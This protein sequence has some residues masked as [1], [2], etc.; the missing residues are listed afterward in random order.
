MLNAISGVEINRALHILQSIKFRSSMV[1]EFFIG[2]P[3][4]QKK[5]DPFFLRIKTLGGMYI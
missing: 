3:S 4:I 1:Y 5:R 2:E